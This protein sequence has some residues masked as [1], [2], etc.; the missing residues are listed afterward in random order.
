MATTGLSCWCDLR[1]YF[2]HN[3]DFGHDLRCRDFKCHDMGLF[4]VFVIV[5]VCVGFG[6][7]GDDGVH[8][9]AWDCVRGGLVGVGGKL[10]LDFC[11]GR[12]LCCLRLGLRCLGVGCRCQLLGVRGFDGFLGEEDFDVAAV[13]GFFVPFR[14]CCRGRVGGRGT[15][16]AGIEL[17]GSPEGWWLG[18]GV[19]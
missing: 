14:G 9:V 7:D 10:Y 2:F 4:R 5:V 6:R 12:R 8:G 1:N 15:D 3:G 18:L 11:R 19:G 16:F 17:L 13:W